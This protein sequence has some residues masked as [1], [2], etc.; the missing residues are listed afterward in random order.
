MRCKKTRC[1]SEQTH[2][3][4]KN[5][6]SGRNALS[7]NGDNSR[8]AHVLIPGC[9]CQHTRIRHGSPKASA[10]C[11]LFEPLGIL[12]RFSCVF[13]VSRYSSDSTSYI[14]YR[15]L[16]T[17]SSASSVR[18]APRSPYL[19]HIPPNISQDAA[20]SVN[21]CSSHLGSVHRCEPCR[22]SSRLFLSRSRSF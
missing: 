5:A 11:V 1:V 16:N 15:L 9:A 22:S 2:E 13:L 7:L 18:K 20:V 8:Y 21:H 14:L 4:W 10:S 12:R 19:S 6:H 3:R 17:T